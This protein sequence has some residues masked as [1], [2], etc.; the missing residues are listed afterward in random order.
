MSDQQ[1][2]IGIDPTGGARGTT[3]AVLDHDLRV[4]V[5][6]E[7]ADGEVVER[8]DSYP[9]AVCAVDAPIGPNRRLMAEPN[10]RR[11]LGLRPGTARYARFRV[12]EYELRRRGIRLYPTPP[13]EEK[14]LGWMRVGWAL[15]D[16][17]RGIGYVEYPR[18]G[19]RRVCEVHPHACYAALTGRLPYTKTH[20]EGR[21]Q[22]Q[23]VLYEEGLDVPDPMR[24]FE[25]WT[26]HHLM[27]GTLNVD[28]LYSHDSLDALVAAY[29]AFLVANEPYRIAV[30]GDPS[31]GQIVVPAEE[32]PDRY[33]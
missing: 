2:Y 12:C 31:E 22:R 24:M 17:L 29:T 3:L 5:V 13:E 21:L 15:Y 32:L 8:V 19:E 23:M 27:R 18:P 28:S 30:V 14:V 11:R 10:Y 6:S 1:V 33:A 20:L 26:R 25:E 9:Q 16:S 7:V 4:V